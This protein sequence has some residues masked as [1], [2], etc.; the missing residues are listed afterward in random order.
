MLGIWDFKKSVNSYEYSLP[1]AGRYY[2]Y[3]STHNPFILFVDVGH[4]LA[5]KDLHGC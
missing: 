3:G 4:V 1:L 2:D 5:G